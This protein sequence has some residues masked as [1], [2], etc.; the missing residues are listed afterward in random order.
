M[1]ILIEFFYASN[2]PIEPESDDLRQI[3]NVMAIFEF[4]VAAFAFCSSILYIKRISVYSAAYGKAVLI[5]A[6][7]T[8]S[9]TII[10]GFFNLWMARGEIDRLMYDRYNDQIVEFTAILLPYFAV[11][12]FLPSIVIANTLAKFSKALTALNNDHQQRAIQQA[13]N[14]LVL[15]RQ[16]APQLREAQPILQQE[17]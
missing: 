1:L 11:T 6:I 14:R 8:I 7:V 2:F 16:N 5:E 3:F 17:P 4:I 15:G 13:V 12:E 10:A 9:A